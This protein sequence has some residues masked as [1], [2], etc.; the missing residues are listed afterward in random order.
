VIAGEGAQQEPGQLASEN[1]LKAFARGRAALGEP[2]E[3][4]EVLE[5]EPLPAR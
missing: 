5:Q 2:L 4:G 3:G 1:A